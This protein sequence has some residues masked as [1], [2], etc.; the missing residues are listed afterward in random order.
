MIG[1]QGSRIAIILSTMFCSLFFLLSN[2]Y[3]KMG[4]AKIAAGCRESAMPKE[5]AA[6]KKL[7]MFQRSTREMSKKIAYIFPF[8]GFVTSL[9]HQGE[10]P[11][12]NVA[13]R[14]DKV[15]SFF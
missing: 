7:F 4:V 8:H 11:I 14:E 1:V 6:M 2:S 5:S 3:I 12:A 15:F 10:R 9:I 13:I